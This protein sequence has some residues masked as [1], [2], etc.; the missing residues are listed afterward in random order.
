MA[1]SPPREVL[2]VRPRLSTRPSLPELGARRQAD[3]Q[4]CASPDTAY[5]CRL[6]RVGLRPPLLVRCIFG[7]RGER[8]DEHMTS[9]IATAKTGNGFYVVRRRSLARLPASRRTSS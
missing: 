6:R 8:D 2:P 3:S 1:A 5:V 7:V 9:V 4:S